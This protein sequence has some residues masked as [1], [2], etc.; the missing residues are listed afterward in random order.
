MLAFIQARIS[1][2]TPVGGR[3][4]DAALSPHQGRPMIPVGVGALLCALALVAG[5]AIGAGLVW[6]MGPVEDDE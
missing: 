5:I 1:A 6:R 2:L 4:T 3:T